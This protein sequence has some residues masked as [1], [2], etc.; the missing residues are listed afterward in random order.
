MNS[1]ILIVDDEAPIREMLRLALTRRGYRV[2]DVASAFEV[3][4]AVRHDPPDL[5]VS[6]LQLEDSDGLAM[7]A[8]LKKSHPNVPVLLLTGVFLDPEVVHGT[9]GNQITAYLHKTT[10][11][12]KIMEE[13][14]RLVREKQ[15]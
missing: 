12:S 4:S 7:I 5:I 9:L 1:H 11:L 2:T 13:I 10:S 14:D 6:D 3:E 8:Q 15:A